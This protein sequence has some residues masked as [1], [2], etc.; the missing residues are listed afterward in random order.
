MLSGCERP[1]LCPPPPA[2]PW[3]EPSQGS[4]R[5]PQEATGVPELGDL[6][7]WLR[8]L[9]AGRDIYNRGVLCPRGA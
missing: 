6:Y 7:A 8:L 5:S 1:Y 3:Q 4:P 9:Q 2:A